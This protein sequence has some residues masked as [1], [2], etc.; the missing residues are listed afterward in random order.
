MSPEICS[1]KHPLH[2]IISRSTALFN[3]GVFPT[4]PLP[5]VSVSFSVSFSGRREGWLFF[6]SASVIRL[7]AAR[8]VD[9][10]DGPP[11]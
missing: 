3:E 9:F 4:T 5:R 1:V 8:R 10:F 6:G 11:S 7:L 2:W